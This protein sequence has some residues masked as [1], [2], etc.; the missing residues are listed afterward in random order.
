MYHRVEEEQK[1][2]GCKYV[3]IKKGKGRKEGGRERGKNKVSLHP[4]DQSESRQDECVSVC[5]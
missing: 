4:N 3:I 1:I 2:K 5:V